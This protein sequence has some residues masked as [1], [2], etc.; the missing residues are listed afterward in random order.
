MRRAGILVRLKR[1]P[2][3][4]RSALTCSDFNRRGNS[5]AST[6]VP[7]SLTGHQPTLRPRYDN[8]RALPV[9][10]Q[11]LEEQ[12]LQRLSALTPPTNF[13]RST[14]RTWRMVVLSAG[15]RSLLRKT[16]RSGPE[17]AS[18]GTHPPA[19]SSRNG[20]RHYPGMTGEIISERWAA[21]PGI[22]IRGLCLWLGG[23]AKKKKAAASFRETFESAEIRAQCLWRALIA[24]AAVTCSDGK[25]RQCA[26]ATSRLMRPPMPRVG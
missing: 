19:R 6:V 20:G 10:W 16:R 5:A 2:D 21:S 15:I 24:A 8:R 13:N 14:S 12:N 17:S 1:Q 25:M 11:D 4:S 23:A 9:S 7:Q 3:A 22:G 18:R 26:A